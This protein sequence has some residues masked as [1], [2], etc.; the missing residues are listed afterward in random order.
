MMETC[1]H[2]LWW[3]HVN[4]CYGGDT[5]TPVM[6]GDNRWTPVMMETQ[7][8]LLWWRNSWNTCH[9][10]DIMYTCV[11]IRGMWTPVTDGDMWIPHVATP[12]YNMSKC[13]TMCDTCYNGDMSPSRHLLCFSTQ[14]HLFLCGETWTPV[15]SPSWTPVHVTSVHHTMCLH[16]LDG[17]HMTPDIMEHVVHLFHHNGAHM[18]TPV[19]HLFKMETFR[20]H[21]GFLMS[22]S[23][24]P[25]GATEH[26]LL[27]WSHGN[28]CYGGATGTPV[29]SGA[30]GN[31]CYD[32]A[33]MEHLLWWRDMWIPVMMETCGYLLWWRHVDTC[34][35][36]D[37]WTPVMMET[38]EH[39]LWWR[40]V[41]TC[42]GGDTRTPVMVET[43][44]HLLWWRN[45]NI[46]YDGETWTPVMMETSG[47]MPLS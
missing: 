12:D 20:E 5:W 1:E 8:P 23:W 42:Y 28:T 9:D 45:M 11:M 21:Q 22:P 31:T 18:W 47:H 4:T 6:C 2:L 26:H 36:G 38:R 17:V 29:M 41:N 44:E 15:T 24:T 19:E 37:T 32:G 34:Y 7:E 35:D 3:R 30:T 46:C 25:G 10:G 43:R 39:L 27:W 40:H 33:T 13:D 14:E 16:L